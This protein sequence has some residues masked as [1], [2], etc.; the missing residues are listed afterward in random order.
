MKLKTKKIDIQG[1]QYI[2]D[3][4]GNHKKGNR[5]YC[6][7][8]G[9]FRQLSGNEIYRVTT[10]TTEEVM[11]CYQLPHGHNDRKRDTV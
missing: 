7:G 10:Q 2:T 5:D 9:V 11:F 6:D 8:M 4:Y 3:K 1:V